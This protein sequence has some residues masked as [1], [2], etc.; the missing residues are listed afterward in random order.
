M[1][2]EG[3][4]RVFKYSVLTLITPLFQLSQLPI[5]FPENALAGL[6]G[7]LAGKLK[8][9]QI[10]VQ[11]LNSPYGTVFNDLEQSIFFLS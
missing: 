3:L 4:G 1:R 7:V 8:D 9:R 2:Q 6:N 5:P 11:I 10:G